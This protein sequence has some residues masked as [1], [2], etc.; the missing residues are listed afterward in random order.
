MRRGWFIPD[1]ILRM[2]KGPVTPSRHETSTC[3]GKS[4]NKDEELEGGTHRCGVTGALR[5]TEMKFRAT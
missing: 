3:K 5:G 4:P 2:G 1:D